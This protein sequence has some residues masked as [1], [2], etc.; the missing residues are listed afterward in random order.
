[1]DL[2]AGELPYDYGFDES[3]VTILSK[4]ELSVFNAENPIPANALQGHKA[5]IDF[6]N[7]K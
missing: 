4:E 6:L 3:F 5:V 2:N 7:L 1:L